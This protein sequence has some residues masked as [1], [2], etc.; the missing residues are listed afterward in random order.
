MEDG[1]EGGA[2][3]QKVRCPIMLRVYIKIH[4]TFMRFVSETNISSDL[5]QS[6]SCF[7][8]SIVIWSQTGTEPVSF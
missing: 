2:Q 4:H 3:L 8:T 7:E 6:T 1:G 5:V